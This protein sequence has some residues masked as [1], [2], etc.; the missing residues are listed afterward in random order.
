MLRTVFLLLFTLVVIIWIAF[1]YDQPLDQVQ[2]DMLQAAGVILAGAVILCFVVSELTENYSQVDKL[3]SILPLIYTGV[4]AYLADYSPRLTLM[5]FVAVIWG[6]RLTYNF[7]RR[8]GYKWPPWRGEEDY[9]W[10]ILRS[11]SPLN[12][13]L[14]WSVF[15]LFFISTYQ[16]ILILSF[17]LPAVAAWEGRQVPL[18]FFDGILTLWILGWIILE[19]IADNQQYHFQSQKYVQWPNGIPKQGSGFCKSG[20][21]KYSRH[22]NYTA[23]QIIWLSFYGYSVIATGRW[24]NWSLAGAILLIVLFLGS[25]N[26]SE[27]ISS[28]KYPDYIRYQQST[29]RFLTWKFWNYFI[30]K[31]N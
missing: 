21:W 13:R 23:E 6:V 10:G 24:I 14:W 12:N 2:F 11:Q 3:W 31:N 20:L 17:T 16:Q 28:Q 8:G 22:P 25:S 26:F 29:P 15:N 30:P 18:G 1:N 4:F 5:W 7:Y 9:R 19:T 27:K